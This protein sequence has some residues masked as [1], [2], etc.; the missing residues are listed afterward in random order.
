MKKIII[1]ENKLRERVDDIQYLISS[2][3]QD[4]IKLI[5]VT[6]CLNKK[7]LDNYFKSQNIDAIFIHTSNLQ[8]RKK[9]FRIVK[10]L[11]IDFPQLLIILYTGGR[12]AIEDSTLKID[13]E[14]FEF[15]IKNK[16]NI[17]A[18]SCS[19]SRGSFL[20]A[21]NLE[22]AFN[23]WLET[24][25]DEVFLSTIQN[26]NI[27][28]ENTLEVFH[29]EHIIGNDRI[30]RNLDE[31]KN[32][33]LLII[34]HNIDDKIDALDNHFLIKLDFNYTTQYDKIFPIKGI[35][36][37]VI[38]PELIIGKTHD[39]LE[40]KGLDVV[41]FIR[42]EIKFL[43]S[44]IF[45]SKYSID[46]FVRFSN[47]TNDV[48]YNV[49]FGRGSYVIQLK[50]QNNSQSLPSEIKSILDKSIPLLP[51][52]LVDM[53][54]M[55][56]SDEGYII[57]VI[58]HSIQFNKSESELESGFDYL[59]S[60]ISKENQLV[61]LLDINALN[62]FRQSILIA[63]RK[64]KIKRFHI[65]KEDL[66][67]KLDGID[68]HNSH[69]RNKYDTH[70]LPNEIKDSIILIED[71]DIIRNTVK[72]A[73]IDFF[74]VE[75]F[76]NGYDAIKRMKQDANGS[77]SI[78]CVISD[79][80]LY[81]NIDNKIWQEQQGYEILF[82]ISKFH[83]AS[84][85]SLTSEIDK[86]IH[87]IRN[88]LGLEIFLFKKQRLN[89]TNPKDNS[90]NIFIDNIQQLCNKSKEL[91]SSL[92]IVDKWKM[93]NKG[94]N[95]I[96]WQD[97]YLNV[98][99]S[100]WINF[101]M[102]I[103]KQADQAWSYYIEAINNYDNPNRRSIKEQFGYKIGYS[104]IDGLLIIRRVW[105]AL[106]FNKNKIDYLPRIYPNE[107]PIANIYIILNDFNYEELELCSDDDKWKKNLNLKSRTFLNSLCLKSE[108]LPHRGMLPEEKSWLIRNNIEVSFNDTEFND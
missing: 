27:Q 8:D 35:D 96:S 25:N 87:N 40:F 63:K 64:E 105:L 20:R 6:Y 48:K 88:I 95:Q 32:Q 78:Y 61:D 86:N 22:K 1:W 12:I 51:S 71:D 47:E 55:L 46:D 5:K 4:A 36:A 106:W 16:S 94:N 104:K 57:D 28:E 70:K 76:S 74:N 59:T 79:W 75:T 100:N 14:E 52:T 49:V 102:G 53:N 7:K 72:E 45:L 38:F 80:R 50:E 2:E 24:N 83:F 33:S 56:L 68:I 21:L 37:I 15:K 85:A 103:S 30:F 107:N 90:W 92:P 67:K 101:E 60:I 73:L 44:I 62:V 23:A 54:E 42:K 3:F 41:K 39:M 69:D 29:C 19:Y 98:R 77:S 84:L 81:E 82:E 11:I 17:I 58:T 18:I 9:L 66:L 99:S 91:I 89:M 97:K 93:R 65:L 108:D 34:H 31:I 13:D 43:G 26:H 10:E